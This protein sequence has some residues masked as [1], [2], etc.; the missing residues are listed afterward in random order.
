MPS[1][2]TPNP[3]HS[4]PH[5]VRKEEAISTPKPPQPES[6][7]RFRPV[8]HTRE[9]GPSTKARFERR[10]S[11]HQKYSGF[12]PKPASKP[13]PKRTA[14]EE[15]L[16]T[17][18]SEQLQANIQDAATE[19]S[20]QIVRTADVL[21]KNATDAV[22][23]DIQSAAGAISD[24]VAHTASNIEANVED[25]VEQ[26]GADIEGQVAKY[27]TPRNI[28]KVA[29]G[30]VRNLA[31]VAVG[32]Q[33]LIM[34]SEH[35]DHQAERNGEEDPLL[36]GRKRSRMSGDYVHFGH[37][38]DPHS[39]RHTVYT[40]RDKVKHVLSSKAGHYS[41]LALVS[42]DVAG[43]IAAF[44][45]ALFQCEKRWGNKGWQEA[46]SAL[47]IASLVF[48]SLF[49]LELILAIWAFGPTY[50]HSKFHIV[51]A[52]VVITGFAL[53]LSLHGGVIEEA[54]SLIV[55]LR[56]WRVFK[57]IEEL[58]LGAQERVEEMEEEIERL[59]GENLAL[60]R[61]G[62]A[63]KR[64]GEVWRRELEALRVEREALERMWESEEQSPVVEQVESRSDSKGKGRETE[65]ERDMEVWADASE[66]EH[67]E[68]IPEGGDTEYVGDYEDQVED[69]VD[70]GERNEGAEHRHSDAGDAK[71]QE[72]IR[73][74]DVSELGEGIISK[75]S[76]VFTKA[77]SGNGDDGE[78]AVG[79]GDDDEVG[80]EDAGEEDAFASVGDEDETGDGDGRKKT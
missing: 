8:A 5:L 50:F 76:R 27:L 33:H 28:E 18:L 19:F 56:L 63:G 74:S 55:V 75:V 52:L 51:D 40:T 9:Q 61:A 72:E 78:G 10:K 66:V 47:E 53:D 42:L 45:I 35:P 68:N 70:E 58:S 3:P 13:K 4:S 69:E 80:E 21:A 20:A 60:R 79:G 1:K 54:A 16:A 11:T 49:M 31:H 22:A 7:A 65:E 15:Q 59:K 43:I 77:P 2:P 64:A 14:S 48:S 57:I 32:A 34:S 44:I 25:T 46:L 38:N 29:I 39:T 30:I 17:T 62:L 67:E 73:D 6:T 36:P 12:H 71:D 41:V 26:L 24:A 37:W 23:G